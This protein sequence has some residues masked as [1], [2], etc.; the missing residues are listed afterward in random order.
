[1]SW[2]TI[3]IIIVHIQCFDH[4]LWVYIHLASLIKYPSWDYTAQMDTR[5]LFT[6]YHSAFGLIGYAHF[7]YGY[8]AWE[9]PNVSPTR[10]E[11]FQIRWAGSMAQK[12]MFW[13]IWIFW[14]I[15]IYL[16]QFYMYFGS[17]SRDLILGHQWTHSWH[18]KVWKSICGQCEA[19][20]FAN[21]K[22][23]T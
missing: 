11:N 4:R 1:M 23:L 5:S 15:R 19:G 8:V 13:K 16:A 20:V 7:W 12:K 9:W 3:T 14:R 6:N 21:P 17:A 2:L 10:I 22:Q 18:Q